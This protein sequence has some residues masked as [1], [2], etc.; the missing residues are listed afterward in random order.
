MV[1]QRGGVDLGMVMSQA[2]YLGTHCAWRLQCLS[3]SG[4][5]Q[6][7]T[8]LLRPPSLLTR[9]TLGSVRGWAGVLLKHHSLLSL[10]F[11]L[12]AAVVDFMQRQLQSRYLPR[13]TGAWRVQD[14]AALFRETVPRG[15]GSLICNAPR[16]R[17]WVK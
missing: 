6:G 1:P 5:I 16:A 17:A 12:T 4:S 15:A 2:M 8:E 7:Q 3:E 9:G 10:K 14:A 11:L 13:D